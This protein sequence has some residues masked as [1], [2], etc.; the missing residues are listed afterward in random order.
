MYPVGW[1][2]PIV[3]PGEYLLPPAPT[4]QFASP[5]DQ[6]SNLQYP[7]LQPLLL[8]ADWI[9]LSLACNLLDHYFTSSPFAPAYAQ[10]PY[11][12]SFVFQ[13]RLVLDR[14]T[15]RQCQ[16]ALLASM[17]CIAAQTI[18]DSAFTGV[19]FSRGTFYEEMQRLTEGLVNRTGTLDDVV[20]YIHLATVG[21]TGEGNKWWTFASSLAQELKLG[22]E[23]PS[24]PFDTRLLEATEVQREERRR[25][26]WLL[27]ITDR[28]L[29]LCYDRPLRFSD[30]ECESLL[31]PMDDTEYQ[32]GAIRAARNLEAQSGFYECTG[33]GIYQYFLTLMRILGEIVHLRHAG[34]Y[35]QSGDGCGWGD[36]ETREIRHHLEFYEQ[37]L[38]IKKAT[39]AATAQS[40]I[41]TAYGMYLVQI[42]HLLLA[43]KWDSVDGDASR[44]EGS[45]G[46][47]M[48]TRRT[49]LASKALGDIIELDAGLAL[50]PFFFGTYI[51]RGSFWVL[52]LPEPEVP[53]KISLCEISLRAHQA[54][55]V[56][57]GSLDSTKQASDI[58]ATFDI[59]KL[60]VGSES[61]VSCAWIDR[62]IPRLSPVGLLVPDLQ[63]DPL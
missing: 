32:N 10:S 38:R 50:M 42:I 29:A 25:V 39:E 46:L 34:T 48:A 53:P 11:V 58:R 54:C 61:F 12:L 5:Q 24:S 16:P 17:M 40:T 20:T 55:V 26:W 7:V 49:V 36:N 2:L 23:L 31:Q 28:H 13:K 44:W 45:Q 62:I 8:Y 41:V 14:T 3:T 27:Y 37:S 18:D 52:R 9:P 59:E 56:A 4:P 6:N 22:H 43:G 60:T 30:A 63:P 19:S 1:P 21:S 51:L 33:H 15:P 47:T 57:L 35:H